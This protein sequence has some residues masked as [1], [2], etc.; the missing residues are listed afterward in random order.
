MARSIAQ[1]LKRPIVEK[2]WQE[3]YRIHTLISEGDY[4]EAVFSIYEYG[5]VL[6]FRRYYVFLQEH[7]DSRYLCDMFWDEA[8]ELY[9]HP[10]YSQ[11]WA[12]LTKPPKEKKRRKKYEWY[13][14]LV[15][16]INY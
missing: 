12:G 3:I 7:S 6:F 14:N 2:K 1:A 13:D 5:M 11:A 4:V 15:L 16:G 8:F 10:I 9:T